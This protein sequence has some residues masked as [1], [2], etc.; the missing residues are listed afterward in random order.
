MRC[1]GGGSEAE[2]RPIVEMLVE[3][4]RAG[5]HG[6]ALAILILGFCLL[7]KVVDAETGSGEKQR[8]YS[9][10]LA[11]IRGFMF[12]SLAFLVVGA[13]LEMWRS[14]VKPET[15]VH[16]AIS[17]RDM[18]EDVDS[19]ELEVLGGEYYQVTSE[20]LKVKLK[21]QQSLLFR[22]DSLCEK[23]K[24]RDDLLTEYIAEKG[25]QND[26]LGL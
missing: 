12:I 10:L 19:P 15:E 2:R 22:V 21:D 11:H 23:I 24:Q 4:V 7:R 9:S 17:P 16:V 8:D 3:L 14:M 20:S 13:S 6:L 26:E 18:P 5:F 1:E 25:E